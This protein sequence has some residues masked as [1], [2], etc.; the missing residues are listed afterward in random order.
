[1]QTVQNSIPEDIGSTI[2]DDKL[3]AGQ[4]SLDARGTID[5]SKVPRK[6][7]TIIASHI[8]VDHI[9]FSSPMNQNVSSA[10]IKNTESLSKDSMYHGDMEPKTKRITEP[11]SQRD[12]VGIIQNQN[13]MKVNVNNYKIN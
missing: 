10:N 2:S 12:E 9:G 6:K 3:K 8:K 7:N 1:M 11:V 4:E 13:R 5:D